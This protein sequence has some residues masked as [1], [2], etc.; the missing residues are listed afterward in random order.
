MNYDVAFSGAFIRI[1]RVMY[2]KERKYSDFC[3]SKHHS[4]LLDDI[5][6][7]GFQQRAKN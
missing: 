7:N 5:I 4:P 3:V 2:R 1:C 6:L